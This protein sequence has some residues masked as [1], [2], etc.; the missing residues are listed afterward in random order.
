VDKLTP[1]PVVHQMQTKTPDISQQYAGM[2]REGDERFRNV[3]KMSTACGKGLA[4]GEGRTLRRSMIGRGR[5][6][7]KPLMSMTAK[8]DANSRSRLKL[9]KVS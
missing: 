2:M 3:F 9:A 4:E 1:V 5:G 8:S 7:V 6:M